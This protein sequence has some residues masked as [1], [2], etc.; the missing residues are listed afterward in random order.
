MGLHLEAV[1]FLT[2]EDCQLNWG[3]GGLELVPRHPPLLEVG[4]RSDLPAIEE[5]RQG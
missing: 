2:A 3:L 1:N 5:I 4:G